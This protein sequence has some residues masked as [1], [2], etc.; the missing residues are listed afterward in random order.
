MKTAEADFVELTRH[1]RE[2]KS[3]IARIDKELAGVEREL[4]K[5]FRESNKR[6]VN[7][8][9]HTI[10]LTRLISVKSI[11]GDT[12]AIVDKLRRARFGEM[13]GVNWPRLF[14]YVKERMQDDTTGTWEVD[15]SKLPPS[16]RDVVD[17]G[18]R[19][20]LIHI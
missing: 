14:S 19:L 11:G 12:A 17:V 9:G 10:Y 1:K 13:I 8:D 15:K 7:I 4:V 16:I 6:S 20:S 3:K 2:L 18:E 5:E